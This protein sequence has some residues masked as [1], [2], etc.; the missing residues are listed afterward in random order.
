MSRL[1]FPRAEEGYGVVSKQTLHYNCS[2]RGSRIPGRTEMPND[3]AAFNVVEDKRGG[4]MRVV[5]A[6][7]LGV[8][9]M[10]CLSL[11]FSAYPSR[12]FSICKGEHEASCGAGSYK[13]M[14]HIGCAAS[15][16]PIAEAQCTVIENGKQ[17]VRGYSKTVADTHDG[18]Q[19]GYWTWDFVCNTE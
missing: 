11:T 7:I 12:S 19:C 4:S 3:D 9:L 17:R 18:N 15:E 2:G 10:S 6:T 5:G 1:R 8:G 13:P 16:T 14:I